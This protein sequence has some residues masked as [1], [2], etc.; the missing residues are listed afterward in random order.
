M[1][2]Q[3]ISIESHQ[4]QW[5][6]FIERIAIRNSF[7]PSQS[8]FTF[9]NTIQNDNTEKRHSKILMILSD[10][11]YALW[12]IKKIEICSMKDFYHPCIKTRVCRNVPS[13]KHIWTPWY[14][15]LLGYICTYKKSFIEYSLDMLRTKKKLLKIFPV[16]HLYYFFISLLIR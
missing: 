8:I 3:R 16:Q 10:V 1:L 4:F 5:N 14:I 15:Y 6:S 7:F 9:H 13:Y 2:V 12:L 11:P